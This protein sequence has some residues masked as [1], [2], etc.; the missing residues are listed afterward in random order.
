MRTLRGTERHQLQEQIAFERAEFEREYAGR[1]IVAF[2]RDYIVTAIPQ[3]YRGGW[4]GRTIQ[5]RLS[6][7]FVRETLAMLPRMHRLLDRA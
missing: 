3:R 6:D 1:S 5:I 2:D 7:A 4:N